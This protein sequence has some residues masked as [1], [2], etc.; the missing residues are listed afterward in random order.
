M[1]RAA[2]G[3]AHGRRGQERFVVVDTDNQR[4]ANLLRVERECD[5]G[6]QQRQQIPAATEHAGEHRRKAQVR[7][8]QRTVEEVLNQRAGE[9]IVP[10]QQGKERSG[11]P[12][13]N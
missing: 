1:R 9:A 8:G 11:P 5:G 12:R 7:H 13:G 4:A 2:D 6:S 3:G 10:V